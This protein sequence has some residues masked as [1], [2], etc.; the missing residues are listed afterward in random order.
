MK[1]V[2]IRLKGKWED[3]KD[4]AVT[5]MTCGINTF[6][7]DESITPRLRELGSTTIFS[8][9]KESKPDV[10]ITTENSPEEISKVMEREKNIASWIKIK[11]KKDEQTVLELSK[12]GVQ[13]II[14]EAEDWKIIPLENLIAELH[15]SETELYAEAETKE[16]A[17][18]LFQ[19]LELGVD[20]VVVTPKTASEVLELGKIIEIPMRLNLVPAR[21]I[22]VSEVGS[23]DRVCIDTC[24]L[25]RKGEGMLIG[26]QSQGLFLIHSETLETEF[27][28]SRPFRVNAGAVHAYVL[29]TDGK[30]KYLS[31]LE[32][33]DNVLAVDYQGMC[34]EV[35]VGRVKI[36]KRP[37][38]L[39]KAEIDSEKMILK[40]LVQNAETVNLVSKD[41]KPVSVAKLKPGDEILVYT[42]SG[43]RHFGK[44]VEETIIEK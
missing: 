14:V 29:M 24:S 30:T 41:G 7:A 38:L 3:V 12:K 11:T 36:E 13:Y 42:I 8:F 2:I 31:E 33:G 39:I 18:T 1:K 26:S 15:K 37:L 5:S 32:A 44:T 23:G 20:G 21:I 35:V 9:S 6:I 28:A 25:L 43:G 4:I 10:L 34:R 16:E 22:E 27:A 19:T 40:T 17:R